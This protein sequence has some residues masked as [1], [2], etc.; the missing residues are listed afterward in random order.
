MFCGS[1]SHIKTTLLTKASMSLLYLREVRQRLQAGDVIGD[2]IVSQSWFPKK[3]R[4]FK[5]LVFVFKHSPYCLLLEFLQG[6]N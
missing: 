5:A 2:V 4:E 3:E 6:S 1:G